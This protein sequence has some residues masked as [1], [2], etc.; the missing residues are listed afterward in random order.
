M[1]VV[2]FIR[3]SWLPVASFQRRF[4]PL[5]R[6]ERQTDERPSDSGTAR[7]TGESQMV[8]RCG[9]T[10]PDFSRGSDRTVTSQVD[11]GARFGQRD[12]KNSF[13]KW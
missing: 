12:T 11:S 9:P 2:S 6:R 1:L 8:Q 5:P 4:V 13:K 3:F 7:S 10:R